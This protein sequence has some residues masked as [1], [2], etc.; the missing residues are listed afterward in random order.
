M[1]SESRLRPQVYLPKDGED[2]LNLA[3]AAER[4]RMAIRSKE[5]LVIV[6]RM[7][8]NYEGR[9]SSTLG[10]G[11]RVLMIKPDGS[12]LI[13]RPTGYEPVN[14]QPPGSKI[15][16]LLDDRLVIEARRVKPREI[17][18]IIFSKIYDVS[19]YK[20]RDEAEF[21]MYATE[22]DM[23]KA[24]LMKPSIIE[25][26]FKPI[27][28]ERKA[29]DVG[30]IDIFGVDSAGR[31]VVVEIKRRNATSEDVKQLVRY[32]EKIEEEFGKRPRAIIVAPGVQ[33]SAARELELYGIEFKALSPR[34]C[35]EILR[36]G[37][38]LERFL[39]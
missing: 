17:L 2:R 31:L 23:R 34:R 15:E 22:E 8:V 24:I 5:F 26:G 21:A 36:E 14:W 10:S 1:L 3:E 27:E 16:V 28:R 7:E 29:G 25:D 12:V 32:V 19:S 20:L 9:A 18:R 33:R 37:K 11:D 30:F 39:K 4:I 35:A 38:G 6:G 13:H